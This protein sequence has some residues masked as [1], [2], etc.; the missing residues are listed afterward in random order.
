MQTRLIGEVAHQFGY[1]AV[2]NTSATGVDQVVAVLVENLRGG[3][4]DPELD[5]NRNSI[6]D[7]PVF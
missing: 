7:L 6:D 4:V 3:T 2:P 1:Q 5:Q